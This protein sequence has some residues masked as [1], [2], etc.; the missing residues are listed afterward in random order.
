MTSEKKI[1]S[2]RQKKDIQVKSARKKIAASQ[3]TDLKRKV[4]D[5]MTKQN[6]SNKTP[7][8]SQQKESVA[9]LPHTYNHKNTTSYG[10]DRWLTGVLILTVILIIGLLMWGQQEHKSPSM[11]LYQIEKAF[12][13]GD[14]KTFQRHVN[15]E[16]VAENIV[17]QFYQNMVFNIKDLPQELRQKLPQQQNIE[18]MAKN[19]LTERLKEDAFAV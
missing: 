10:Q 12:K 2:S 9:P 16:K 15:T 14:I 4:M 7:P 19:G 18:G 17:E 6:E 13:E 8:A 1:F 11:A 5:E 3:V